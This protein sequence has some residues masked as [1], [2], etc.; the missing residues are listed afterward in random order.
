MPDVDWTSIVRPRTR[1][2]HYVAE[3]YGRDHVAQ[4]I[5][6]GTLKARKAVRDEWPGC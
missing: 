6:F 4:I 5:T 3:K 1:V 2:I